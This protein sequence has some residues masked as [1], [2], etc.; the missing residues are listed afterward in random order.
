MRKSRQLTRSL[1]FI[2]NRLFTKRA[3][4]RVSR[5]LLGETNETP[6]QE[7]RCKNEQDG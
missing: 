4:Y 1:F 2:D 7:R 5:V 3:I 6:K